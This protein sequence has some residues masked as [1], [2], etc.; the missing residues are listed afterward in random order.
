LTA[1]CQPPYS[2]SASPAG[3]LANFPRTFSSTHS[4]LSNNICR[5]TTNPNQI[6]EHTGKNVYQNLRL[7]SA[8]RRWKWAPEP[9]H[10][11]IEEVPPE[12]TDTGDSS[13]TPDAPIAASITSTG[14]GAGPQQRYQRL[15]APALQYMLHPGGG[16]GGSRFRR[17]EQLL[18]ARVQEQP[19]NARAW[20]YLGLTKAVL[21]DLS[22]AVG[23]LQKRVQMGGDQQQASS[24]QR[25]GC[26]C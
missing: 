6:E 3:A 17:D 19:G 15:Q 21:G 10:E 5:Y 14:A 20:Y 9:V 24:V 12:A 1:V 26:V 16:D 18:L 7:V 22:G 25:F 4:S 23:V 8:R 11:Y 2:F 13:P